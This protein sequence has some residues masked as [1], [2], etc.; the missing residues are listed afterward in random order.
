M[1]RVQCVRRCVKH[2]H[3]PGGQAAFSDMTSH[4]RSIAFA[5]LAAFL[6]HVAPATLASPVPL[7]G[8]EVDAR[9]LPADSPIAGIINPFSGGPAS[10]PS[11]LE[12]Y[13]E[14]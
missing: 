6:W 1:A 13:L 9:G 7:Q 5:L 8:L 4:R 12:Q 3:L 10:L 2:Y 11:E 14:G